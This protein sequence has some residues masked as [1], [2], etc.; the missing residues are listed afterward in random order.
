MKSI[1]LQKFLRILSI[2][3]ITISNIAP[4]FGKEVYAEELAK[5]ELSK[6]TVNVNEEFKVF[7]QKNEEVSLEYDD[8][9]KQISA[10]T[11]DNGYK[12]YTFLPTKE[13]EFSFKLYKD[14]ILIIQKNITVLSHK[15]NKLI[16]TT[17]STEESNTST[18]V[19]TEESNTSTTV[20][21]EESNT[22]TTVST[23]ESN[24]K[25]N[26]RTQLSK[27]DSPK[28]TITSPSTITS[29]QLVELS[30]LLGASKGELP[31]D[32][33]IVVKI[34]KAIVRNKSD[35]VNK[36]AVGAP[37]SWGNP[38]VTEEG[39]NYVLNLKYDANEIN[40]DEATA[41]TINFAFQAPLF[42]EGD[43]TVPD[44]LNF[45]VNVQ[46]G[47]TVNL[48]DTSTSTTVKPPVPALPFFNKY[49]KMPTSKVGN[50]SNVSMMDGKV[51][52]GNIFQLVVNYA[53]DRD[54]KNAIV[55][56]QLPSSLFFVEPNK[57]LP[58]TGDSTSVN[59]IRILKVTSRDTN[60][61]P[62]A[63]EYVTS[64][65]KD[66][67]TVTDKS[68]SI[69]FGNL[70]KSDSYVVEYAV[71]TNNSDGFGVEYNSGKIMYDGYKETVISRPVA[72]FNNQ[73]SRMG[74]LKTVDKSLISPNEKE[75]EYS[76][77]LTSY[78]TAIPAGTVIT[79]QLSSD[80][81]FKE[82]TEFD[83]SKFTD[84][85]YDPNTNILTYKTLVPVEP[86]ES[87]SIRF[88]AT[89]VS[90]LTNG[91]EISNVAYFKFNGSNLYS[92]KVTTLMNGQAIL[93]KVD[94][95]TGTVLENAVFELQDNQGSVIK[96]NLTTDS[97]G[98]IT[99]GD[100][101]PG[102]YKFVEIKAPEGYELDATPVE[103]EIVKNQQKPISLVK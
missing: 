54:V 45:T 98:T 102:K 63:W 26:F 40:Q 47:D 46:D 103:F 5:L 57:Y 56:D 22:S 69:S 20:S 79:D 97:S 51:F 12:E 30:V 73:Y 66:K 68:F 24:I 60:G 100:L 28:V 34:P 32:G 72:V 88:K 44:N 70:T 76:L 96:T 82:L 38:N 1:I 48:N 92:N 71:G 23:E 17:V 86:G 18:T 19:S 36:A 85:N 75:L 15:N 2:I 33:A 35:L 3:I 74:L 99:V 61:E 64:Q 25:S 13:G 8:S 52:A 31:K 21:T 67:I 59:H 83:T 93:R 50:V 43:T 65:F 53:G 14:K 58:A 10:K 11:L 29:N 77:E 80:L 27:I 49:G 62:I 7:V 101:L 6:Q 9:L 84:F 37:F 41:Y 39:D 78:S 42:Y 4:L 16:S 91:N 87:Y 55:S 81:S 89:I 90:Q 94:A 95:N